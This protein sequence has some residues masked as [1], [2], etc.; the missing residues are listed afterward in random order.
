MFKIYDAV[1]QIVA[2]ITIRH[3]LQITSWN[4]LDIFHSIAERKDA[5]AIQFL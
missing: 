1:I 4:D 5:V 3:F 2:K